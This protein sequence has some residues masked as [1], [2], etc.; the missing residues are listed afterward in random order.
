M[1]KQVKNDIQK[2]VRLTVPA[3]FQLLCQTK[4]RVCLQMLHIC[5]K[6]GFWFCHFLFYF[7]GYVIVCHV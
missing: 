1:Q 2:Q 6:L 5:H 7:V 3:C 4:L